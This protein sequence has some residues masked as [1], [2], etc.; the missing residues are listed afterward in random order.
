MKNSFYSFLKRYFLLKYITIQFFL[1]LVFLLNFLVNFFPFHFW[2][3]FICFLFGIKIGRHSTLCSRIRFLGIGNCTI[4]NRSIINQCCTID[5]RSKLEIGSNV[6]IAANSAIWTRGHDVN[7][8]NFKITSKPVF[9]DDYVCI[10]SNCTILPGVNLQKGCVVYPGS[11]VFKS[12]SE[13]SIIGGNPAKFIK[14]RTNNYTYKIDAN[15]WF[16]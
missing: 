13:D 2:K 3:K 6:S 16:N 7:N 12:F 4:G 14:Y 11:V 1:F 9:I 10:F 8:N 5:N 15:F